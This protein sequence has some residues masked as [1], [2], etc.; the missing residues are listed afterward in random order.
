MIEGQPI[1][2]IQKRF[3]AA[4]EGIIATLKARGGNPSSKFIRTG[5]EAL[6]VATRN[7]GDDCSRA[8]RIYV[9]GSWGSHNKDICEWGYPL[10]NIS[11]DDLVATHADLT[12]P[13]AIEL[14]DQFLDEDNNDKAEE[15]ERR[16]D[17]YIAQNK[18]RL[19]QDFV[20]SLEAT[21]HNLE[22]KNAD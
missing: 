17:T 15:L 16:Y 21:L 19:A 6:D 1:P 8:L 9:N 5:Y 2:E 11:F 12:D 22:V 14:S 13:H 20:E 3:T 7:M 18:D 10:E 4:K